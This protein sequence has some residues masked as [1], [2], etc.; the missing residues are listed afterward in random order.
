MPNRCFPYPPQ[1]AR[2]LLPISSLGPSKAYVL[3]CLMP[4][5]CEKRSVLLCLGRYGSKGQSCHVPGAS[6]PSKSPQKAPKGLPFAVP[7][8]VLLRRSRFLCF[9]CGFLEGPTLDPL[10]QAQSKRSLS[11]SAWPL[12]GYRVYSNCWNISGEARFSRAWGPGLAK[13]GVSSNRGHI[14]RFL[15]SGA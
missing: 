14:S 12:K 2:P 10:A 9:L 7:F 15:G 5:A 1:G 8:G 6:W 3:Q 11:F 4:W 13:G